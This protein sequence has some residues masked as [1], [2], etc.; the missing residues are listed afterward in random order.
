VA[1]VPGYVQEKVLYV[2]RFVKCEAEVLSLYIKCQEE[3]NHFRT[4][5]KGAAV[6]EVHVSRV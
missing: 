3:A 4:T 2:S 5:R 1:S 6:R